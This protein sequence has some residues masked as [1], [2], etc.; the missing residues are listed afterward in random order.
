MRVTLVREEV[1]LVV[2]VRPTSSITQFD[3]QSK[4]FHFEYH[5]KVSIRTEVQVYAVESVH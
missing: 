4:G 5:G 3:F 2:V 1:D